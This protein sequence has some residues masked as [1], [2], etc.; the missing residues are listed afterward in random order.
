MHHSRVII[1]LLVALLLISAYVAVVV[2]QTKKD[3]T[4]GFGP[5]WPVPEVDQSNYNTE[6]SPEAI[7]ERLAPEVRRSR[8]ACLYF[9]G[10]SVDHQRHQVV[11]ERLARL[12]DAVG[13]IEDKLD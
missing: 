12:D 1:G 6:Y 9:E 11:L 5:P 7:Y 10:M 4:A 13:A 8:Y 3:L 2:V